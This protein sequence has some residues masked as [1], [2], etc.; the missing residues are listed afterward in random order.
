MPPR[1]HSSNNL[2]EALEGLITHLTHQNQWHSYKSLAKMLGISKRTVENWCK[3][4]G[5][6]TY[7]IGGLVFI[8]L[9]D[10]E[11]WALQYRQAPLENPLLE[12]RALKIAREVMR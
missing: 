1:N 3:T 6:P 2:L 8:K 12:A 5:L 7:K 11:A 9:T 10:F 4:D